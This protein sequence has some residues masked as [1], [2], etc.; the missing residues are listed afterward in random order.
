MLFRTVNLSQGDLPASNSLPKNL[1]SFGKGVEA[2]SGDGRKVIQFLP[3]FQS[4]IT[5]L[6]FTAQDCFNSNLHE[7]GTAPSSLAKGATF[8]M[9]WQGDGDDREQVI[10][11][12]QAVCPTR[13]KLLPY[14]CYGCD[15]S[16]LTEGFATEVWSLHCLLLRVQA[17]FRDLQPDGDEDSLWRAAGVIFWHLECIDD[18]ANA[19]FL[20]ELIDAFNAHGYHHRSTIAQH[21]SDVNHCA[22]SI[23]LIMRNLHCPTSTM[24]SAVH[25]ALCIVRVKVAVHFHDNQNTAQLQTS[26]A[27]SQR[28]HW[29]TSRSG[30]TLHTTSGHNHSSVTNRGDRPTTVTP[31]C[32]SAAGSPPHLLAAPLA[33]RCPPC[34]R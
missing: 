1:G 12:M 20:G 4:T 17:E 29:N 22:R 7:I 10:D 23:R 24:E 31:L 14:L 28:S 34:L 3:H 18:I 26:F 15:H 33:A 21:C 19:S 6:S 32:P 30:S 16:S 5:G 25:A 2:L 8:S 11:D 9:P 13:A 27:C